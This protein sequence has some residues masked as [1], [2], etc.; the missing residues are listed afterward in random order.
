MKRSKKKA[1]DL[2]VTDQFCGAGGSSIGARRR[3]LRVRMAINHWK[4]AIETHQTN[5]PETD[6][7]CT[8]ISAC[9]PRRYPSTDILI[10]SPECT[11]HSPAGGSRKPKQ[12]RDLF[13]PN[14]PDAET[15]RSR[16][17]MYDVTRFAEYHDYNIIIVE[18]VVEVITT[19]PL[20]HDWL[21]MMLTLGYLHRIVSMNSMFQHPTPQSRDRIYIV[22]WKRG[23]RAPDLD[24]HPRAH[25]MKC[26]EDVAAL[27]QWKNGNSIG[28]YGDRKQY[29]YACPRCQQKVHPYYFAA[30]NAIDFSLPG[31][32]IGDR[33]RPLKPRT[34]ERIQFGLDRYG[35]RPLIV[36]T[37]MT[38]G[39][40]CRVRDSSI[41]PFDS[42]P[43][44]NITALVS[45]A[46]IMRMTGRFRVHDL[47]EPLSAQASTSSQ[48][49]L[50]SPAPF[51]ST[52]RS[53]NL[54]RAVDAPL[55]T[56]NTGDHHML[57]QPGFVAEL[58]NTTADRSRVKGLDDHLSTV[59]AGG[60]NHAF[61]TTA[62]SRDSQA[63]LDDAMPTQT[64]TERLALVETGFSHSENRRPIDLDSALPAQTARQSLALVQGAALLSLRDSGREHVA[65]L[66]E[67][68]MTQTTQQQSG[69]ASRSPFFVQYYGTDN[70][71]GGDD[72]LKV[73]TTV[74]RNLLIEPEARLA[75]EDCYFRMLQPHEIGLA[76]AFEPDYKVLGNKRE[77]IKQYGNAVTPPAMDWLLGR[78]IASLHPEETDK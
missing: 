77:R 29:V 73:V 67:A 8:D 60:G 58:A 53:H 63:G 55:S 35:S 15:E 52:Q 7:D 13:M 11:T 44:T 66:S 57:I 47:S 48:D 19:W 3:G 70:A 1:S 39:I 31:T 51:I 9:D 23:N 10:T 38:S 43:S 26:G 14:S 75:I 69:V 12:Q 54:P 59:H 33:P 34:I 65:D 71:S 20:F 5:F 74:D 68:T 41:S 24:F 45:P 22:F 72:P 17:T 37:T 18:N 61:I 78:C 27:Q 64:A 42:Q 36:R 6:H 76:M 25:C 56:M 28:K 21:K 40:S 49:M 32:R 46:A 30:I 50:L 2:T 16:A 62:G 4:R